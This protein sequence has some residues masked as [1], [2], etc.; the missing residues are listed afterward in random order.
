MLDIFW[1]QMSLGVE[2]LNHYLSGWI[3]KIICTKLGKFLLLH[4]NSPNLDIVGRMIQ[5]IRTST[6]V[7]IIWALSILA[8]C[9]GSYQHSIF[10]LLCLLCFMRIIIYLYS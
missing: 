3:F 1:R 7:M 10:Y 9:A 8:L 2:C 5:C 6:L 4:P